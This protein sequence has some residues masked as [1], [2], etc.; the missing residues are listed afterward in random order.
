MFELAKFLTWW[1]KNTLYFF[2]NEYFFLTIWNL[3]TSL[4]PMMVL[5][6]FFPLPA[7]RRQRC[8]SGSGDI[9]LLAEEDEEAA[10]VEVG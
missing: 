2:S 7:R 4:A 10:V 6:C 3:V 1:S 9:L 5:M 8:S